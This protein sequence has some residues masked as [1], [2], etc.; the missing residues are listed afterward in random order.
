MSEVPYFNN[1]S[2]KIAK[3]WGSPPPAP[4]ISTLVTWSYCTWFGQIVSLNWLRRN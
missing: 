1:K 3:R 2:S 4:F